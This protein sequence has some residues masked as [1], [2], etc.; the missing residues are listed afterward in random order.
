MNFLN[1]AN[2]LNAPNGN[3]NNLWSQ[4]VGQSMMI[5]YSNYFVEVHEVLHCVR[6]SHRR[7]SVRKDVIRTPQNSQKNTCARA[8][9]LIKLQ[10]S[11][12]II[13]KETLAQVLS[14]EFCDISKNTFF[15]GYLW[16]TAIDFISPTISPFSTNVPL[17]DKPG[18]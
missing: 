8:S 6:S 15:T 17:M 14:C 12:L 2:I 11:G 5:I 7:L 16:K 4:K 3:L 13:K 1:L 18:S 10:A 9:F